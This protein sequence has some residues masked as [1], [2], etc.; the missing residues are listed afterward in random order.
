[1]KRFFSASL[2]GA[3]FLLTVSTLPGATEVVV[4]TALDQ[5]Y[6][7]PLLDQFEKTTGIRVLPV[8]DTEAN[9][10]VGLVNRL[11]AEKARPRCDVFWN[12]EIARTLVLK[13]EN[14]LAPYKSPKADDIPTRYRDPENY[15]TGFAA[16]ARI[17]IA[18][19]ELV[20]ENATP[21]SMDDLI[22][23]KWKGKAVIANPLFG[24]TST[25]TAALFAEIGPAKAKDYFHALKENGVTIAA[26]NAMVRDMVARGERHFGW[27]DTDDANG[28]IEDGS[29]VK[30]VVPDQKEGQIGVLIIPNTVSLVRGAPNPEEG[31]ALIDFLLTRETEKYLAH[32]RSAQIPVRKGIPIPENVLKI[33]RLKVMDVDYSEIA[34]TL[35]ESTEFIHNEFVP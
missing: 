18:N 26:G 24:T 29:P 22:D 9:K 2:A 28:A 10:T 33:E 25:H 4:Y 23:L 27:T 19:T 17:L 6:S 11:M 12:N 35:P 8:Y 32:C 20:P 15:W 34:D 30:I 1:M 3:A 13:K 7:E 14:V 5:I 21:T 16:R 31:K